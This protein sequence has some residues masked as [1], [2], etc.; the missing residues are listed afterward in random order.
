[1]VWRV[2][3]L[4]YTTNVTTE[5]T[6]QLLI[7]HPCMVSLNQSIDIYLLFNVLSRYTQTKSTGTV[8]VCIHEWNELGFKTFNVNRIG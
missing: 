8:C 7:D 1:M 4:I 3:Q 2:D 6:V 5:Y